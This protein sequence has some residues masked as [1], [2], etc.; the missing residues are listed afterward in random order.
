MCAV[1][2]GTFQ[3]P[4]HIRKSEAENVFICISR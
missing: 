4:N 3:Q 2:Y 1:N